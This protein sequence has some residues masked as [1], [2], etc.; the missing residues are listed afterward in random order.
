MRFFISFSYQ[1][2]IKYLKFLF[3][4]ELVNITKKKKKKKK[5]AQNS[6]QHF[7]SNFITPSKTPCFSILSSFFMCEAEVEYLSAT[8]F[9]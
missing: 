2:L 4:Y 7:Y 9:G 1:F 3:T 8:L 5:L 6:S